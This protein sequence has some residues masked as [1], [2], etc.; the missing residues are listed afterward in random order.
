MVLALLIAAGLAA[1]TLPEPRL[2]DL[3]DNH[4]TI[5]SDKTASSG[6]T[7]MRVTWT[8]DTTWTA[9]EWEQ[10][11]SSL[12][13][14]CTTNFAVL[15]DGKDRACLPVTSVKANTAYLVHVNFWTSG[16]GWT[17]DTDSTY[18]TNIQAETVCEDF[19]SNCTDIDADGAGGGTDRVLQITTTNTSAGVD[20]PSAPTHTRTF[21]VV[22]TIDHE[23]EVTVTDG[24]CVDLQAKINAEAAA[25]NAAGAVTY[26]VKVPAGVTCYPQHE[27]TG[28]L[29]GYSIPDLTNTS[30]EFVLYSESPDPDVD[31][32]PGGLIAPD[33]AVGALSQNTDYPSA[34][35]VL[36]MLGSGQQNF[37]LRNITLKRPDAKLTNYP[38]I[39]LTGWSDANRPQVIFSSAP[40][41]EQ[42]GAMTPTIYFSDSDIES[43]WLRTGLRQINDAADSGWFANSATNWMPDSA[44]NPDEPGS[45]SAGVASMEV[46]RQFTS[47]SDGALL[48]FPENI[49]FASGFVYTLAA[50]NS[51]TGG[52]VTVDATAHEDGH[53][54]NTGNN[55][56]RPTL[57]IEGATGTGCNGLHSVRGV[58]AAGGTWTIEDT[59]I[60]CNG[61]TAQVLLK[62]W[63]HDLSG[64]T[65]PAMSCVFSVETQTTVQLYLCMADEYENAFVP[66]FTGLTVSGYMAFAPHVQPA[67]LKLDDA[68][69]VTVETVLL[70]SGGGPWISQ[71]G[72]DMAS[73]LD[74][75]LIVIGTRW[76]GGRHWQAVN[77][78]SGLSSNGN[79]TNNL[80]Y[81]EAIKCR[82]CEDVQVINSAMES[83]QSLFLT[84]ND[85]N[86][87][88]PRNIT[89]S[90]F[91]YK[92]N[93][94]MFSTN[95]ASGGRQG[96]TRQIPMEFKNGVD[97]L[98]VEGLAVAN[99][100]VNVTSSVA[101][102]YCDVRTPTNSVIEFTP[103][104]RD[105]NFRKSVVVGMQ[106]VR[107]V[108]GITNASKA[109]YTS[110][111][112]VNVSDVLFFGQNAFSKPSGQQGEVASY[113]GVLEPTFGAFARI[114][115]LNI[116]NNTMA[117][118]LP[119]INNGQN[120]KV[121]VDLSAARSSS[122]QITNNVY[123]D[124][125]ADTDS[126]NLFY[127]G[128]PFTYANYALR[129]EADGA[130]ST[131]GAHDSNQTVAC[132]IAPT[133][134]A[135]SDDNAAHSQ[136]SSRLTGASGSMA[137]NWPLTA[138]SADSQTCNE[139]L[140]E[141]F[142][143]GTWQPSGS[144]GAD[145]EEI[146]DATGTI[147]NISKGTPTTTGMT[148][149]YEAPSSSSLC[150]AD[151][152]RAPVTTFANATGVTALA[153]S[154]G[155]KTPTATFTGLTPN[156]T[157]D[158]QLQ[159]D[160]GVPVY[161]SF[162]TAAE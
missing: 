132:T 113:S 70:D 144:D 97:G 63:F 37:R 8:D 145:V 55:T 139:R 156:T 140:D 146:L 75:D 36:L 69:G 101:A 95:T 96:P 155:T 68:T 136:A 148:I 154:S 65:Y 130:I 39:N 91:I 141:V 133:D 47:A 100:R 42:W 122:I 17:S 85:A 13:G 160:T 24:E 58:N 54:Y 127:L 6:I 103:V 53:A 45:T 52:V 105:I 131:A 44:L 125:D 72:I 152:A 35:P 123:V 67:L 20:A 118:M 2:T 46:T 115:D 32:P 16:G 29:N 111:G 109:E 150:D 57:L 12:S 49:N 79:R 120:Y 106:A 110:H 117:W 51:I 21:S 18:Q 31:P 153:R 38:E 147:R 28:V 4:F 124:Q 157:Y 112:P 126:Y 23:V 77:P 161:V 14:G 40:N 162:T 34:L 22:G 87:E 137:A 88:H 82:A 149:G 5:C 30:G 41:T 129:N 76:I 1:Q 27:S 59:A 43:S 73:S 60:T 78:V 108:A 119:A 92:Q 83:D 107:V 11:H 56:S 3:G 81:F 15:S 48:T 90:G 89:I 10:C 25:Y 104:C 128:A 158:V 93:P 80:N 102:V 84:S 86:I 33:A 50:T 143:S 9:A 134:T 98:L 94:D 71:Y 66:D 26:A 151:Y 19:S 64:F 114:H 116:S 61:G 121:F 159:C 135:Y 142:D 99:Q 138:M 62:A 7:N 74:M